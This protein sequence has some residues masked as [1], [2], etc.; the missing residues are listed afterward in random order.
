MNEHMFAAA[1]RLTD[2]ALLARI[3]KLA[4]CE[5]GATVE[6]VAHLAALDA[7]R[8]HL[9]EGPSSLYV[10]CRDQLHLSED[11]AWNRAA[12]ASAVRRYPIILDWLADGSLNVT[13]VRVL[14]PVLTAENHL[15]VL[16]EAKHR[17]RKEVAIIAARINPKPDVP[18]TIRKLPAPHVADPTRD[19]A[20]GS[21][22]DPGQAGAATT[23]GLAITPG[24]VAPV[25]T[26]PAHRAVIAP[27]APERYKVQFTVSKETHDK[28]RRV[29]DLLCREVPNGDPAAIFDRALDLLLGEVEKKKTAA[30]NKPRRPRA[31]KEGSRHIPRQVRRDVWKRDGGRC[32]FVGRSGRCTQRRYLE[33]HHIQPH[34]HQG[35]PTLENIALRCRAHNVY[36]SELVFGRFDASAPARRRENR[37]VSG[38]NTPVPERVTGLPPWARSDSP[39]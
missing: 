32:A 34:G 11:A 31:T 17:S 28:L 22:V 25:Q 38:R 9:G 14:R 33:C 3:Q 13:T 10:Y 18:S 16:A 26:P 30:T 21:K 7:R 6:L 36:E 1:G 12:T 37:A 39:V 19:L 5:R 29:Q 24:P 27:L 23:A 20:L 15:A 8:T 2:E 35:P 4:L